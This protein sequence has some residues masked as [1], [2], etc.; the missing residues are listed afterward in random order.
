M[1]SMSG[2]GWT[3]NSNNLTATRSGALNAGT[4]YSPITIGFSL[5]PGAPSLLTNTVT[6]SGGGD[7]NPLNNTNTMVSSV[8]SGPD[9]ALSKA[10]N[11]TY[12]QGGAG[13]F[14][15][16][17]SNVGGASTTGAVTVTEQP[18]AG[19][20][21][22]SMSG[23]GWIFD[24]QNLSATRS[25]SLGAGASYPTI[26]VGVAIAADAP[27]SL[28]NSVTLSGGSNVNSDNDTTQS[29]ASIDPSLAPIDE[30][31]ILHFGT[32]SNSGAAADSHVAT[33]DGMPN[34]LKY[35]LGLD[36]T[37]A[38]VLSEYPALQAFPPLA[39]KFRRAKDASDV[40]I[41]VEATDGMLN[42]WTNIWT[43]TTNAY[44]GGA[45]SFEELV[46]QDPAP[47]TNAQERYLRLKV[48]RP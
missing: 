31:R 19:M 23:D 35:A 5:S 25:D 43:S 15:V 16:T 24:A 26:T 30:W 12:Q 6:V 33:G 3:F 42:A 47:S 36:P 7:G 32:T 37:N 18:P 29:V 38:A 8:S 14:T 46:V 34:L 1:T 9:L 40:V 20:T 44:G 2:A 28:T 10:T 4:N 13:Q 22:T 41:N 11:S 17:V 45:N 39:I 21:V 27:N 48:I